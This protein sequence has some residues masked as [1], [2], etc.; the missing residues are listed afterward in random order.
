MVDDT[1]KDSGPASET[2]MEGGRRPRTPPTIELEASRVETAEAP[3]DDASQTVDAD[4][5]HDSAGSASADGPRAS[6][7]PGRAGAVVAAA[8]AG[9]AG[10]LVIGGAAWF[11]GVIGNSSS[12]N[13]SMVATVE[14]LA[15]RVARL[16]AVP[17][18][19]TTLKSDPAIAARVEGMEKSIIAVRDNLATLREQVER[20]AKT[21]DEIKAAPASV[22]AVPPPDLSAFDT[23]IAQLDSRVQALIAQT[24]QIKGGQDRTD[25]RLAD[26]STTT[27][28]AAAARPAD[29]VRV[30]RAIAAGALDR[31][32]R[33]GEPFAPALEAAKRLA[34]DPAVLKPLDAFAAT[35]LPSA[36]SLGLAFVTLR[37]NVEPASTGVAAPPSA[38]WLDRL[39]MSAERLVKIRHEGA[40]ASS[41]GSDALARSTA[42][43]TR[44]DLAAVKRELATLPEAERARY[45][46]WIDKV[47]ARDAALAAAQQFS[48]NAITAL[49][50]TP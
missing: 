7:A 4:T 32:V 23:R 15:A 16:E 31:A 33:D 20:M 11:A 49:A 43:A 35:G 38:G 39:R 3:A 30:R 29:E 1:P 24:A 46:P 37:R 2:V 36:T 47:A 17:P 6:R 34:E 18:P 50:A 10:A 12:Q 14:T 48:A 26:I 41:D 27:A 8:L 13:M 21:M 22:A 40:A 5:G 45:Q 19:P 44:G 9:G 28:K 42:A 25:A